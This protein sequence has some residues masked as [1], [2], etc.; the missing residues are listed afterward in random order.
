MLLQ[1]LCGKTGWSAGACERRPAGPGNPPERVA[2]W[3]YQVNSNVP[4]STCSMN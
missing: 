2:E 1:P 3:A 4:A